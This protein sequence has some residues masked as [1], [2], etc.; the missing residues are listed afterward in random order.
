[1]ALKHRFLTKSRTK[2]P[3]HLRSL[4]FRASTGPVAAW[5]FRIL[6]KGPVR[7]FLWRAASNV[8]VARGRGRRPA[9]PEGA[10]RELQEGGRA[11]H[12][13]AR[14]WPVRRLSAGGPEGGSDRPRATTQGLSRRPRRRPRTSAGRELWL[15]F[16][17]TEAELSEITSRARLAGLD[18]SA[19]ARRATLGQRIVA[20]RVPAIHLEAIGQLQRIGN[21]LNQAVRLV[22]EGRLSPDL[23]ASV[24]GVRRLLLDLR[25]SLRG[26]ETEEGEPRA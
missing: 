25:R 21:N 16:R 1:M 7:P 15:S 10:L 26:G 3:L 24:E 6:R 11:L 23:E 14:K 9:C 22:H 18:R 13:R 17:V 8:P 2:L 12:F 5:R 20:L 4:K 19:Y